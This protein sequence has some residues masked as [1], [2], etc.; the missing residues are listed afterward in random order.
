MLYSFVAQSQWGQATRI[1]RFVK[2]NVMWAMLAVMAV[3]ANELD[4]A[5]VALAAIEQV[6]KLHYI[7]H[8]KSIASPQGRAAALA[9]YRR[10]PTDAENILLQAGMIYRAIKM[11]L[12][13]YNW[14]RA[15]ELATQHQ[16]HMDTVLGNRARF[17][18]GMRQEE[19]NKRFLQYTDVVI[20]WDVIN[21][22]KKDEEQ[23]ENSMG[24]PL[25]SSYAT[26]FEMNY[27]GGGGGGGGGHGSRR[28]SITDFQQGNDNSSNSNQY[29][30]NFND[31]QHNT[32]NDYANNNDNP[33]PSSAEM[34]AAADVGA[35]F[36]D[37][38]NVNGND[39]ND[40]NQPQFDDQPTFGGT[41]DMFGAP[42]EPQFGG[43]DMI[44]DAD[45]LQ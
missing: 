38:N 31:T 44:D 36:Q 34:Q 18:E 35:G 11:H 33:M 17:L 19:T 30:S 14:D 5:E 22:K 32:G 3:H 45:M 20:D 40:N 26:K 1:C 12:R 29:Q 39:M 6:D 16:V 2:D 7:Q 27:H 23:R 4:T 41:D 15:L 8:I 10:R 37:N 42:Q 9:L 43:D 13:M 21:Q 25:P 24:Q 28:S